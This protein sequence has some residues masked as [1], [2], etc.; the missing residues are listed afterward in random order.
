[1]FG[2]LICFFLG[3]KRI[4]APDSAFIPLQ[5]N[6]SNCG[7]FFRVDI[8]NRCLAMFAK[9]T[10]GISLAVKPTVS[11]KSTVDSGV[12]LK[13]T[14]DLMFTPDPNSGLSNAYRITEEFT[15][16]PDEVLLK[17]WDKKEVLW[18]LDIASNTTNDLMT[19]KI[20]NAIQNI[21]HKTHNVKEIYLNSQDIAHL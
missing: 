18:D 7:P 2:K 4:E 17:T 11:L 1:M 16:K 14:I 9:K 15:L 6:Y 21:I 12:R 19:T 13:K 10:G 3:H 5:F 8:C 20:Y